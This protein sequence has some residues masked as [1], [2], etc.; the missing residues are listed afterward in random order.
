MDQ[1][2]LNLAG[3][4]R[5]F[6]FDPENLV[7]TLTASFTPFIDEGV[8]NGVILKDEARN[9]TEQIRAEFSYRVYWEGK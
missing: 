2:G 1:K 3:I 4:C 7:A 5:H 6:G 9:W 8:E